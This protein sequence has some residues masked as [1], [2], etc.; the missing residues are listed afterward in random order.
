MDIST[1]LKRLDGLYL[2]YRAWKYIALNY[3]SEREAVATLSRLLQYTETSI[4]ALF[5]ETTAALQQNPA[6]TE[7]CAALVKVIAEVT[8]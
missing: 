2:E 5:D 7:V 1:L 3:T 4:P 8:R 6:T